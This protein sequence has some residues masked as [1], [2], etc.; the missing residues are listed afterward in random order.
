MTMLSTAILV[1]QKESV[2]A[3]KYNEGM[4]KEEYW[5]ANLEDAR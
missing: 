3:Q 2:F 1:M 4:P 5:E